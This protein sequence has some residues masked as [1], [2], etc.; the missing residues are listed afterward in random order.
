[1]EQSLKEEGEDDLSLLDGVGFVIF[2]PRE[3]VVRKGPDK[4]TLVDVEYK[5]YFLT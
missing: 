5:N 3:E 1:M 2:E 4:E